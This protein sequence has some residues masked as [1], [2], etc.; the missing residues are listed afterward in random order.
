MSVS[1]IGLQ[2]SLRAFIPETQP[3]CCSTGSQASGIVVCGRFQHHDSRATSRLCYRHQGSQATSQLCFRHRIS[4]V[5]PQAYAGNTR[6]KLG[7]PST[8]L[9][10]QPTRRSTSLRAAMPET[11]ATRGR[12][13]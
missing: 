10:T 6:S 2:A 5:S 3:T 13:G 11:A 4:Q 8:Q 7:A 12:A 1:L 9:E